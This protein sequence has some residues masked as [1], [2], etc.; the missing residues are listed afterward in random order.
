MRKSL[1]ETI[2]ELLLKIKDEQTKTDTYTSQ[3]NQI[4]GDLNAQKEEVLKKVN[5]VKALEQNLEEKNKRIESLSL[6]LEEVT[7]DK[8]KIEGKFREHEEKHYLQV[9][10]ISSYL[11]FLTFYI[12]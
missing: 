12:V 5:S 11:L 8:F 3:L 9:R 4:N 6:Q 10:H 1:E 7:K 2:E